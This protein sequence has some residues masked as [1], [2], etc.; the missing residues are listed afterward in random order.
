MQGHCEEDVSFGSSLMRMV[1]KGTVFLQ[2]IIRIVG[3]RASLISSQP[4][5]HLWW[6]KLSFNEQTD[7]VRYYCQR[8]VTA[9]SSNMCPPNGQ[10][11]A[12]LS[13]DSAQLGEG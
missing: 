8:M 13:G 1:T 9:K 7:V 5:S 10:S 11:I 12:S 3:G 4:Y 2:W 6:T